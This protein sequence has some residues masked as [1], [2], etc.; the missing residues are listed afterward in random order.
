MNKWTFIDRSIDRTGFI[1]LG[2]RQIARSTAQFTVPHLAQLQLL[3][4]RLPRA[5][6]D[7][8]LGSPLLG[9][10]FPSPEMLTGN[11]GSIRPSPDCARDFHDC[12]SS[13]GVPLVGLVICL[14]FAPKFPTRP[15]AFHSV[16]RSSTGSKR[17]VRRKIRSRSHVCICRFSRRDRSSYHVA[18]VA[19][20]SLAWRAVT[21]AEGL[22]EIHLP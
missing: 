7:S 8:L 2:C 4:G 19:H 15:H 10:H 6:P 3:H 9:R 18:H 12:S 16:V 11:S 1:R 13:I 21:C 17:T 14:L 20:T 22:Q 5:P